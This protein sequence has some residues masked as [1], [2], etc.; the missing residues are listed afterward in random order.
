MAGC[1]RAGAKSLAYE[2]IPGVHL[3]AVLPPKTELAPTYLGCCAYLIAGKNGKFILVDTL[4]ACQKAE[5]VRLLAGL[6]VKPTDIVLVAITHAHEDHI[7]RITY[8]IFRT[9]R[10]GR[11]PA[12]NWLI[13]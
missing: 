3:L 11:P 2:L 5:L 8:S 4:M 1:A 9:L 13:P 10:R 12:R 6:G 7:G